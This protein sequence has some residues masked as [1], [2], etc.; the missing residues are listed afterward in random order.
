MLL[1]A[2][3]TKLKNKMAK[4]GLSFEDRL[5]RHFQTF[6]TKGFLKKKYANL[7]LLNVNYF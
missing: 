6:A 2:G 1:F 7:D 3:L 4:D 5:R